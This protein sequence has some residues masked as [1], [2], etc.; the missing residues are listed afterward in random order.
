M[1]YLSATSRN[2]RRESAVMSL[3]IGFKIMWYRCLDL[4]RFLF[5]SFFISACWVFCCLFRSPWWYYQSR[6]LVIIFGWTSCANRVGSRRAHA[7]CPGLYLFTVP[8]LRPYS[9]SDSTP[10]ENN[11]TVS[12][13]NAHTLTAQSLPPET[14]YRSIYRTFSAGCVCP[15]VS[16]V[17]CCIVVRLYICRRR[18]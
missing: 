7:S 11:K 17:D 4:L 8:T 10:R 14:M 15:F 5:F 13:Y 16:R 2:G 9:H 3:V 18:D 12:N 6:A 1:Y